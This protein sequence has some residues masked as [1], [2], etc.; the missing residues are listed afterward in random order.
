MKLFIYIF[1]LVPGFWYVS[2]LNPKF[3]LYMTAER[4]MKETTDV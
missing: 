3:R 4:I 2:E 1:E